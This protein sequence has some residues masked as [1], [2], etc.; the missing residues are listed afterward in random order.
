MRQKVTQVYL[1]TYK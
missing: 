1:P